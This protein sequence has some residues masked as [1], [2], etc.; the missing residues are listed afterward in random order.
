M[1]RGDIKLVIDQLNN[2][3][4]QTLDKDVD[5][6]VTMLETLGN[7][8][9]EQASEIDR[10]IGGLQELLNKF[11]IEYK[12]RSYIR[13]LLG[14]SGEKYETEVEILRSQA[15][16]DERVLRILEL[17]NQTQAA[18]IEKLSGSIRFDSYN[19]SLAEWKSICEVVNSAKTDS[20]Q[21]LKDW[22][23]EQLGEPVA[24]L[25]QHE[26]TGRVGFVDQYQLD[27]GFEKLNPRLMVI[28]PLFK[29][30][31]CLK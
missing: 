31:E 12:G 13:Q 4:S 1:N 2:F 11:D 27:N 8:V 26:D 23:R 25:Y 16:A 29:L 7:K 22:M 15:A 24:S 14:E 5:D 21:I 3:D 17:S 9:A 18:V 19:M 10:L 6:A 30:P 20:K 28:A